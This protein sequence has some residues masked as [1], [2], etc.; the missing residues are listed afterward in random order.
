MKVS[1]LVLAYNHERFIGQA[2]D[3]ALGQRTDFA[4]EIVVGDDCSTD[5]TG[6]IVADYARRH[7]ERI[8]VLP[9]PRNLGMH[10]NFAD[11]WQ[12]CRGQYVAMLEG[13]DFWTSADKLAHQVAFLDERPDYT[14]CFTDVEVI[15][16][17]GSRP[18]WRHRPPAERT[19]WALTDLLQWNF[20]PQC[21]VMFRRD[22]L[23][24][25]PD[26]FDR[27]PLP[28]W[29]LH[30]LH[31]E[32][33]PIGYLPEVTATYRI[34]AGGV[35]SGQDEVK[36]TEALV[37]VYDVMNRHLGFRYDRLVRERIARNWFGLAMACVE[38]GDVR[39]ARRYGWRCLAARP[40]TMLWPFRLRLLFSLGAPSLWRLA[41]RGR[42]HV[43][44][45]PS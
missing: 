13:D 18:P 40:I 38:R 37:T 17:D 10:R 3:S 27:I 36:R 24:A 33:G 20:V 28:D 29:S 31:A 8:R 30:L 25:L 9:R 42:R 14:E 32:R 45:A 34:H 21:S 6:A 26:W 11:A 16:Q 35:H 4:W 1:V 41:R 39:N 23:R 5:A 7:P 19:A 15:Y 22:V 12:A 44:P 2:L 43:A